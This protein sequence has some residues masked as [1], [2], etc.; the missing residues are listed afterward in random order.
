MS[1][2]T[3]GEKKIWRGATMTASHPHLIIYQIEI[4]TL[5]EKVELFRDLYPAS[6]EVIEKICA[7]IENRTLHSS[8]T[9]AETVLDAP[10]RTRGYYYRVKE[11]LTCDWK[12]IDELT[13]A[14][15]ESHEL[16]IPFQNISN[17]LSKLIK[18]GFAV[19]EHNKHNHQRYKLRAQEQQAGGVKTDESQ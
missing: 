8:I 7:R 4:D 6:A 11:V 18:D 12:T 16:G 14:L 3:N 19:R 17:A 1:T 9:S 15:H 2:V 10:D 5:R 13:T